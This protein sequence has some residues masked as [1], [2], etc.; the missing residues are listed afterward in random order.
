MELSTP[1]T[2]F[3]MNSIYRLLITFGR[4]SV[5]KSVPIG[6]FLTLEEMDERESEPAEGKATR[7]A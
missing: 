6:L 3:S 4:R 2:G 1:A 7:D 5:I